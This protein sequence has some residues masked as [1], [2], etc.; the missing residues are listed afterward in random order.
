MKIPRTLLSLLALGVGLFA[1]TYLITRTFRAERAQFAQQWL[2]R[3]NAAM[4]AAQPAVAVTDFRTA[5]VYAQD[6]EDYQFKLAKA[7]ADSGKADEAEAY[8]KNLWESEPGSAEINLQLARLAVRKHDHSSAA[9]FFHGAIYG[10]W[11]DQPASRRN[12]ARLE[13][14]RFL[15]DR[16]AMPQADAELIALQAELPETASAHKGVADLFM[17]VKDHSR[18]LDEYR[19][20]AAFGHA[21]PEALAGAGRAAFQLA[22]YGVAGQYLH[23]AVERGSGDPAI[24]N[25]A[26][27]V[28]AILALDPYA[29][30]IGNGE[31]RSRVIR[32]FG[33]AGK[34]L[35]QCGLTPTRFSPGQ[36][37]APNP[38]AAGQ[39][40]R[41]PSSA[42]GGPIMTEAQK[43]YAEWQQLRARMTDRYLRRDP[44][45]MN[46]AT[47]LVFRIEQQS[48][49][50]C[51]PLTIEDQALVLIARQHE[52][53]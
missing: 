18:A 38:T 14:I 42:T 23:Q 8:F 41:A 27:V 26:E 2:E 31:R 30:R 25:M 24:K 33:Q 44:D 48:D 17:K 9:R 11:P 21:D 37:T 7:L 1:V 45:L 15:L 52:G 43:K 53:S 40:N 39:P 29:P 46:I 20:V 51:G 19:R 49:T 36:K 35:S 50:Q 3:G 28:D 32:A 22:Q 4:A 34:R 10:V 5:L 6:N 13:L 16:G 47:D 12:E